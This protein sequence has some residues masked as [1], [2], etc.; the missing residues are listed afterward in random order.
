MERE[1]KRT[2]VIKNHACP[3]KILSLPMSVPT[4]RP[5][6]ISAVSGGRSPCPP[7]SAKYPSRCAFLVKTRC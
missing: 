1:S 2:V 4:R 6:S 3:Q 5:G 7:N